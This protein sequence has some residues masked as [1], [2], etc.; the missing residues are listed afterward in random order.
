MRPAIFCSVRLKGAVL[1]AVVGINLG[2]I[3]PETLWIAAPE[4]STDAVSV[5]WFIEW[6]DGD[7]AFAGPA[8]VSGQAFQFPAVEWTRG[9]PSSLLLT[10]A[11]YRQPLLE[12]D[13]SEGRLAPATAPRKCLANVPLET[14]TA[15]VVP[16]RPS[17]WASVNGLTAGQ[18]DF[19]TTGRDT[20]DRPSRCRDFSLE[21]RPLVG[22]AGVS[23]L[24]QL[25][26]SRVLLVQEGG[27]FTI[28]TANQNSRQRQL[29]GLPDLALALMPDDTLLFGGQQGTVVRGP[30]LGPFTTTTLDQGRGTVLAV[31]AAQDSSGVAYAFSATGN[32]RATLWRYDGQNWTPIWSDQVDKTEMVQSRLLWLQAGRLLGVFGGQK[33][34][35]VEND[36]V[37]LIDVR[38]DAGFLTEVNAIIVA[39][40]GAGE[41]V[42]YAG[43]SD[44]ILYSTRV[45]DLDDWRPIF[46]SGFLG[47]ILALARIPGGLIIGG[48][49]GALQTYLPGDGSCP[50]E[51]I[52]ASDS[53][54]F[55]TLG[56]AILVTGGSVRPNNSATVTILR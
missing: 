13:L 53:E 54:L 12:L 37:E 20:C 19:L 7:F 6:P 40:N 23:S 27:T 28:V 11:Y 33:I 46:S 2:C 52:I 44:S 32:N 48:S 31:T 45:D 29:D 14:F 3:T 18:R 35:Q 50:S 55:G 16:G 10:A 25:D 8:P 1:W 38:T 34:L 41:P 49:A 9:P 21:V 47:G 26:E 43:G 22:T 42:I 30:L 36:E 39:D 4:P 15:T 17:S 51:S 5:V 56:E 24:V